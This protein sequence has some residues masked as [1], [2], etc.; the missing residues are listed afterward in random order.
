[1]GLH[2][3]I[4]RYLQSVNYQP[5]HFLAAEISW[6]LLNADPILSLNLL[7]AGSCDKMQS[8]LQM[9]QV[10]TEY[11]REQIRESNRHLVYIFNILP[12]GY[13]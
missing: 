7:E 3:N 8:A 5:F 4:I 10:Q 11:E 2:N 9:F 12:V 13:F 6:S 1:M